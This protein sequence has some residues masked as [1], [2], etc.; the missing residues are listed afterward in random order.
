[1]ISRAIQPRARVALLGCG[2]VGGEVARR[3]T[4]DSA[5]L[6]LELVRVLVR[7]P[8]RRRPVG[9]DLLTDRFDEVVASAPDI[10]IELLGG[11]APAAEYV[12]SLLEI[13]VHVVTANKTLVAHRAG[14]LAAAAEASGATL[15]YE[16]SVCAGVPVLAALRQLEGDRV[17]AVR[18]IVNGSCNYIL[19]RMEESGLTLG[20][21]L[22]EAAGR[23]LVEPDPSADISGRD[24]AEK[25]CVLARA[26]GLGDLTPADVDRTGIESITPGDIRSAARASRVVRLL[27]E[28]EAAGDGP[29]ARVGPVLLPRTHPLASVRREENGV[30]VE[31]DLAGELFFRGRGAG[32]GPTASAILGDLVRILGGAAPPRAVQP[33]RACGPEVPRRHAIRVT[34]ATAMAPRGVL[35][36]IRESGLVAEE[37]EVSTNSATVVA[38]ASTRG[39]ALA[40]AAAL[41]GE[42]LVLPIVE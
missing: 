32:P 9:P 14:A 1:M 35:E 3:L 10:V 18:G 20:E 38:R 29:R 34:A 12:E 28:V 15:A 19:C 26:A 11:L 13:G 8:A 5:R 2:N 7:D 27:A 16:A 25:L 37:V 30:F 31:A 22:R 17:R 21:A 39:T 41:P 40:C 36:T 6:G 42:R 23:G 24:S 4:E 33:R